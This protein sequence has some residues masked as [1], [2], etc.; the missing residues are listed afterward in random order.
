MPIATEQSRVAAEVKMSVASGESISYESGEHCTPALRYV[1][2]TP[3][4]NEAAFIEQTVQAVI[5]QTLQ[6]V[7]WVIVNDGSTDG[8]GEIVQ[9]YTAKYPWIELV[10]LPQRE[11][12]D[13]AGKVKAFNAGYARLGEIEYDII[14]NLDADITFTEDYFD[15]LI[16]KFSDNPKLGVAGTP[17]QDEGYRYDYNIVST[18][19]VSG[20]CQLFRRECLEDIGGYIASRVGGVDLLAVIKARMKGWVTQSFL[21]KRS[22]HHRTM[23]SA[24]DGILQGVFNGGRVDYS[25]GCDPLWQLGRCIYRMGMNRPFLLNGTLCLAGYLWAFASREKQ[26]APLDLIRFR[27]REERHRLVGLIRKRVRVHEIRQDS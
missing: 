20:A 25:L 21:E 22:I 8:T 26:V 23:G 18:Q 15:F 17:F 7:K 11:G 27:R 24:K 2:I 19:H 12:R 10:H 9:Q 14:G 16:R 5:G 13:F 1:L 6:P 3:A 4:R